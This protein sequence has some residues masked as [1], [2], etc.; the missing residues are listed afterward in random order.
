M[1]VEKTQE[2]GWIVLTFSGFLFLS[3]ANLSESLECRIWYKVWMQWNTEHKNKRQR[4]RERERANKS[5][6]LVPP[7][8]QE[9]S[10]IPKGFH[11]NHYWLQFL[12]DSSIIVPML[13]HTCKRILCSR[14]LQRDFQYLRTTPRNFQC[15]KGIPKRLL[16]L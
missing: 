7:I 11:Y 10:P 4:E 6:L 16:L 13:K 3:L 2:E 12:K 14:S 15:S 1:T 5:N 9:C 8:T